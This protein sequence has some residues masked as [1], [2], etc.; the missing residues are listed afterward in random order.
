LLRELESSPTRDRLKAAVMYGGLAD[1]YRFR[2]DW[3][4][5]AIYIDPGISELENLLVAFGRPDNR[6]EHYLLFST[7]YHLD[8]AALPPTLLVH[9]EK[10]SIVPASQS[11]LIDQV[12]TRLGIPHELL[13]YPDIEH[14]LDTSQRDPAQLDM[15]FK[16]IDFL[17]RYS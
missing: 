6:P 3:E 13:I 4:R 5:K 12:S 2:Y 15:L 17:K 9:A 16:T 7:L 8:R 14:Y 1:M 11:R 10:D